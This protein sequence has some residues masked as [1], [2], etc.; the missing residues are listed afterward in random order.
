ME[1]KLTAYRYIET[2]KGEDSSKYDSLV[3]KNLDTDWETRLYAHHDHNYWYIT[4]HEALL[5]IKKQLQ[6]WTER[7]HREADTVDTAM[8][9]VLKILET[10]VDKPPLPRVS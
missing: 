2:I 9:Q 4:K 5:A 3:F 6:E 7:R 10:G 1:P 8:E